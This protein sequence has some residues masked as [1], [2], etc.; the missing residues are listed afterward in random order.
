MNNLSVKIL[1][2]EIDN[3]TREEKIELISYLT[4]QIENHPSQTE[5]KN[6]VEFFQNSPLVG[7]NINLERQRDFDNREIEL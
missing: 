3:L 7:V 4:K 5:Q 6:L 1:L 2:K